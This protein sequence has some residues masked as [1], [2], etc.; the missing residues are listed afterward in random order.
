MIWTCGS[1]DNNPI[2]RSEKFELFDKL[3]EIDRLVPSFS[4]YFHST[5]VKK[6]GK[7]EEKEEWHL[8]REISNYRLIKKA[9]DVF[10]KEVEPICGYL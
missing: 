2:R 1:G 4:S 10:G 6:T 8:Y 5:T 3:L 9:I 7:E